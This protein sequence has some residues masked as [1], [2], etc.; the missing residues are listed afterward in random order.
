MFLELYPTSCGV[1]PQ[2][3]SSSHWLLL[4]LQELVLITLKV[5]LQKL[6]IH[7]EVSAGL[8]LPT[9][10][11][12]CWGLPCTVRTLLGPGNLLAFRISLL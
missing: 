7:G 3:L 4:V 11:V 1:W 10:L 2:D 6:R 12:L 8:W 9:S 5:I